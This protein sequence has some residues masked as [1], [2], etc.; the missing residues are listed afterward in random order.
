MATKLD[1]FRPAAR[2]VL[3]PWIV[4]AGLAR[5]GERKLTREEQ[6]KV[7]QATRTPHK[8]RWPDWWEIRG[9]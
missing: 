3:E 7:V 4:E 2:M 8:V 9:V 1:R 5:L 6:A